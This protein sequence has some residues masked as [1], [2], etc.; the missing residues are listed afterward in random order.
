MTLETS[1]RDP[2]PIGFRQSDGL[3]IENRSRIVVDGSHVE[4]WLNNVQVV[5]YELWSADWEQRVAASKFA[6]Y[7]NFGRARR[8]HFA[9]QDHG[10]PVYYRN[11]KVRELPSR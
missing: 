1:S 2:Q 3:E 5:N 4:Y 10:N 6:A 9:L 11:M 7:S 8:G